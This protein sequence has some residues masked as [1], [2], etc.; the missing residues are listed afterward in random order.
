MFI[1]SSD[2]VPFNALNNLTAECNYGGRITD[3]LDRRLISSMLEQFYTPA[4]LSEADYRFCEDKNYFIPSYTRYEDYIDYITNLPLVA[5]PEAFGLHDNAIMLKDHQDSQLLIDNILNTLPS[6]NTN[7]LESNQRLI[8]QLCQE[9]CEK[10]EELDLSKANR[11]SRQTPIRFDESIK[12]VLVRELVNFN[13]LVRCI[14]DSVSEI[15]KSLSGRAIISSNLE[16]VYNSMLM[17][18]IPEMWAQLSYL[19]LKPLGSYISDLV[20]RLAFFKTWYQNGPP[21]SFWLSGF[22]SQQSFLT[23]IL[24]SYSRSHAISIDLL[25]Y[26]FDFLNVQPDMLEEEAPTGMYVHGLYLQGARWCPQ[27][28]LIQESRP[29]EIFS[30]LPVICFRPIETS[31]STAASRTQPAYPCPVYKTTLRQG[32]ISATGNSTNYVLTIM[33]PTQKDPRHWVIR[34]KCIKLYL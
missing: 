15:Q 18:K 22:F 3:N 26:A 12:G 5:H 23:S 19:S 16:Q 7:N 27:E 14:K 20:D 11:K 24:Q 32:T 34:S 9:I 10:I 29:G 17:G 25:E 33:L 4:L 8:G 21:K 31:K 2:K 1:E 13:R 6:R 30:T 28:N